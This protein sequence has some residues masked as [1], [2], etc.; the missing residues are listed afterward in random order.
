VFWVAFLKQSLNPLQVAQTDANSRKQ[1]QEFAK[2]CEKKEDLRCL[3]P[4]IDCFF[5]QGLFSLVLVVFSV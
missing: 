4:V 3:Q 2:K 1:M 5:E